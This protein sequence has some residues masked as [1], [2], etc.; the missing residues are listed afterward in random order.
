MNSPFEPY[1]D[2]PYG[3]GPKRSKWLDWM[4]EMS[5]VPIQQAAEENMRAHLL[6]VEFDLQLNDWDR[7]FLRGV[8]VRV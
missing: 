8:K 1:R 6:D 7:E 2:P 4:P 3:I 5:M